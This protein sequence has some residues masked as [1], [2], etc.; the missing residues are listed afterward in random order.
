M[1]HLRRVRRLNR[2][3]E[4]YRNHENLEPEEFDE[5]VQLV[6]EERNDLHTRMEAVDISRDERDR[7]EMLSEIE[8]EL[9]RDYPELVSSFRDEFRRPVLPR[10]V[11]QQRIEEEAERMRQ[12]DEEKERLEREAGEDPLSREERLRRN[13]LEDFNE[14]MREQEAREEDEEEQLRERREREQADDFKDEPASEP[15]DDDETDAKWEKVTEDI[16]NRLNSVDGL[17]KRLLKNLLREHDALVAGSYLIMQTLGVSHKESWRDADIDI[18]IH[19]DSRPEIFLAGLMTQLGCDLPSRLKMKND[20]SGYERLAAHINRAYKTTTARGRKVQIIVT[21]IPPPQVVGQFDLSICR[22]AL[23]GD[24]TVQTYNCTRKEWLDDLSN[25]T[26]TTDRHVQQST[27]EWIRTL[28]RV[29][30]YYNRAFVFEPEDFK[31]EIARSFEDNPIDPESVVRVWNHALAAVQLP[32]PILA[33]FTLGYSE[34]NRP[35]FSTNASIW[36]KM[37]REAQAAAEH[38]LE[39]NL[40]KTKYILFHFRRMGI[41]PEEVQDRI[42]LEYNTLVSARR[43]EYPLFYDYGY[44][45]ELTFPDQPCILRIWREE[46]PSHEPVLIERK[47][48]TPPEL[49]GNGDYTPP[50]VENTEV[51]YEQCFDFVAYD[52]IKDFM[53]HLRESESVGL[54]VGRKVYCLGVEQFRKI[55]EEQSGEFARDQDV[56]FEC[57]TDPEDERR[58][59]VLLDNKYVQ[60]RLEAIFLVPMVDVLQLLQLYK[61]EVTRLYEIKPTGKKLEYTASLGAATNLSRELDVE[62]RYRR[63]ND[64]WVSADHCQAG[65]DK[66]LY[67]LVPTRNRQ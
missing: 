2:L 16:S 64:S 7:Y 62:T 52:E 15:E 53:P 36:H 59:R 55:F 28:N 24:G 41:I 45:F 31:R 39:S 38:G 58:K 22:V 3:L 14:E 21:R 60:V 49:R 51:V 18:W 50:P 13:L 40:S 63:V 37:V 67:R 32:A 35:V 11:F 8:S 20:Q 9:E 46:S 33:Q 6:V 48:H 56:M 42:M 4:S 1:A 19:Q 47:D 44:K 57:I 5:M 29:A 27:F 26:F 25:M 54:I 30:K 12:E 43:D 66:M 17:D 65:S 10:N 34:D 61:E 23:N